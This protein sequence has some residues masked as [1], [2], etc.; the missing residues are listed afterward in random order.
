MTSNPA[1][2]GT[3]GYELQQDIAFITLDAPPL[4]ILTASVMADLTAY[5]EFALTEPTARGM[6]VRASGRAFSAG[7]DVAE[8]R[9][10][11]APEM[12][13]AFSRLFDVLAES[14]LPLIM[15]V[16]G[17]ALGAGFELAM[18]ADILIA[19]ERATFGQPEIRL[20]FFAPLGVAWLG[21]RI[22][23]ARAIE[24]TALGRTYTAEEMYRF[25]LVSRVVPDEALDAALD[26]IL[27]DLRRASAAVMRMNVRLVRGL[28]DQPFGAARHKAER[29]F[30][31]E[32]MATDDVREGVDAFY[33]K[34]RPVWRHC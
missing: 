13:A 26:A 10:E 3:V 31:E 28:A 29:V 30:L 17:A 12:I 2:V 7:A 14:T 25:G 34:R 18:M 27:A 21:R 22:G 15:V 6:V 23:V 19:T 11:Q 20:G 9:P 1:T 24:V 32:L 16:E 33:K 8:H 5:V 4:N